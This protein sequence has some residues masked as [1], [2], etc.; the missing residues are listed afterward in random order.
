MFARKILPLTLAMLA[1]LAAQAAPN[2]TVTAVGPA[3]STATAINDQG[4]VVGD[5]PDPGSTS[6]Y[7]FL[8]GSSFVNL[9]PT[10][11]NSYAAAINNGGAV[12]GHASASP[13]NFGV[14]F[15]D[16]PGGAMQ[17]FNPFNGLHSQGKGI[18]DAGQVVGWGDD[19]TNNHA[20]LLSNG[21]V[22][23]LGTLGGTS[24][25]ASAINK[26]GQVAGESSTAGDGASHAY[27]YA[28]GKMSDLGTLGGND[29]WGTAI[30]DA[31]VVAGYS[32][33]DGTGERTH[34]F[35]YRDGVMSDL[36]TTA[37]LDH[38]E[39]YGINNAGQ[40]VGYAWGAG[41][42]LDERAFLYADGQMIDLN[43]LVDPASGWRIAR[44]MDINNEGQIAALAFKDGVAYAVRLDLV[45][46]VP[47]PQTAAML[48]GGL[49][50]VGWAARR[51]RGGRAG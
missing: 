20:F 17:F 9:G 25:G 28:N 51:R 33:I 49:G 31:G 42:P 50:L 5:F 41:S 19:F 26:S 12:V 43:T 27:L 23:D 40:V 47:E 32:T 37:G 24:S 11:G 16:A 7:G 4:Q 10:G 48:A 36:G 29:S 15:S 34:A 1:P 13:N 35:L 3:G 22:T 21:T 30:N 45:S 44:A 6:H 39:A 46:A 14:A 2:Y 8:A 38:A 18:N